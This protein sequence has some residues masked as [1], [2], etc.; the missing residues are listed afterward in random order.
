M[1]PTARGVRSSPDGAF[2]VGVDPG[3]DGGIA[4]L[5]VGPS[6]KL[7]YAADVKTGHTA[8]GPQLLAAV[9][10]AVCQIEALNPKIYA[11]TDAMARAIVRRTDGPRPVLFVVE[12]QFLGVNPHSLIEL[13]H[14]AGQW[15]EAALNVG[16]LAEVVNPSTWQAAELSGGRRWKTAQL[17]A[18]ARD[19][20]G[21]MWPLL[22]ER[23]PHVHAAVLIAR[24]AAVRAFYGTTTA[25]GPKPTRPRRRTT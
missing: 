20:V 9:C 11:T 3:A 23:K 6:P 24:W 25:R 18:V 17:E 14:S 10:G 8:A 13:A 15:I 16:I 1:E 21:S 7:L 19:K 5:T 22:R 4:V 2:V 12:G